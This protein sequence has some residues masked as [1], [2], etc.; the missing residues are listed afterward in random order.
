MPIRV[1]L[2]AAFA[3][4]TAVVL[5]GAGLFVYVQLRGDL[6]ESIDD[7][8]RARASAVTT[9]G[10]GGEADLE[11]GFARVLGPDGR[12]VEGAGGA[13]GPLLSAAERRRAVLG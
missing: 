12:V 10:A 8:L 13:S 6:D 7:A 1:R 2:T 9:S 11:D 4:A 3:L 5:T